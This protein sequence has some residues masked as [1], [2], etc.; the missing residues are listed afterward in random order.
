[1]KCSRETLQN[2][3]YFIYTEN[4]KLLFPFFI[5]CYFTYFPMPWS[6]STKT[7]AFIRQE[8]K[9]ARNEKWKKATLGFHI[10]KICQISKRFSGSFHQA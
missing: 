6:I 10:Y 4:P 1:M 2:L 3:P 9:G 7:R 5:S 8:S